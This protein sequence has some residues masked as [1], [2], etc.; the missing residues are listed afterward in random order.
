MGPRLPAASGIACALASAA[1]SDWRCAKTLSICGDRST[2]TSSARGNALPSSR[3][4]RP[5]EH[6]RSTTSLAAPK[7][8]GREEGDGPEEEEDEEAEA[9]LPISWNASVMS[10]A[11]TLECER[12]RV[13]SPFGSKTA[14]SFGS[15]PV[16]I[17]GACTALELA[18]PSSAAS[19]FKFPVS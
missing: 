16:S 10:L 12:L 6:P 4:E 7:S 5:T 19:Q 13:S 1:D 8:K 2:P 9:E 15:L 14:G 3:V 11:A 17:T 18:G